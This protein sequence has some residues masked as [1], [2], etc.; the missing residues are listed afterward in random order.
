VVISQET[1]RVSEHYDRIERETQARLEEKQIAAAA[2]AKDLQALRDEA[3]RGSDAGHTG[4]PVPPKLLRQLVD[5]EKELD[6][7]L[8]EKRLV[9][10]RGFYVLSFGFLGQRF[11]RFL[12]DC[13]VFVQ[14]DALSLAVQLEAAAGVQEAGTRH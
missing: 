12:P 10:L 9:S 5:K 7:L 4:R 3:A 14:C 6:V 11:V 13:S 8:D 1:Q 2:A